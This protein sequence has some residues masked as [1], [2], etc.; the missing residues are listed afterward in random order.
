MEILVWDTLGAFVAVGEQVP[1]M[2]TCRI[3]TT[4]Q[5]QLYG[6]WAWTDAQPS[7]YTSSMYEGKCFFTMVPYVGV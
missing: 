3:R 7:K 6:N 1:S 5:G 2:L 4:R